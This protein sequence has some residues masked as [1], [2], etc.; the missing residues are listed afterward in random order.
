MI[1]YKTYFLGGKGMKK[2]MT[3]KDYILIGVLTAVMWSINMG[4]SMIMSIAGPVTNVF[5]PAVVAI[6]NGIVMMLLLAKSPRKGIFTAVGVLQ[7]LLFLLMGG[8]WTLPVALI[9]GGLICDFLIIGSHEVDTK[10]MLVS[11][12]VFSGFLAFGS[13]VLPL[14]LLKQAYVDIMMK[15]GLPQAYIDGMLSVSSGIMPVVLLAAGLAGGLLGGW[16]GQ[17]ALKKH[18]IKAGLV[19]VQ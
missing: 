10:N 19:S 12:T 16:I 11:Y 14:T 17:K 1:N 15:N 18:F 8:F 4:I 6:P 7:G 13:I 3:V 9:L 5:Y 2:K